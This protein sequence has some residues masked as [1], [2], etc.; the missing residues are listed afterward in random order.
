MGKDNDFRNITLDELAEMVARGFEQTATKDELSSQIGALRTEMN[1]GF[2]H[3]N[4]TLD[5]HMGD[6]RKQTDVLAR[7]VKRLEEAVFGTGK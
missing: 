6:V 2:A 4:I 5:K 1:A 3:V 7:R